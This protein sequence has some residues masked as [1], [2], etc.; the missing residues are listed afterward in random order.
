MYA[1]QLWLVQLW[2]DSCLLRF[3][4]HS[5]NCCAGSVG[6][7]IVTR[8]FVLLTPTIIMSTIAVPDVLSIDLQPMAISSMASIASMA[9]QPLLHSLGSPPPCLRLDDSSVHGSFLEGLPHVRARL[10]AR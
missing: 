6:H 4:F 2:R 5:G 10:D 8:L 9:S 3:G 1:M 7:F